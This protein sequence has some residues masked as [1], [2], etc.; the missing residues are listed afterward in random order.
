[1]ENPFCWRFV[2]FDASVLPAFGGLF[3]ACII[4]SMQRKENF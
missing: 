1:M 3:I 4:F 2:C